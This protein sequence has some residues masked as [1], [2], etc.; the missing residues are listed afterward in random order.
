MAGRIDT[1]PGCR[2]R[3]VS[4]SEQ[5]LAY[6]LPYEAVHLWGKSDRCEQNVNK[7]LLTESRAYILVKKRLY[8]H[9]N[10]LRVYIH[11]IVKPRSTSGSVLG[12]QYGPNP[13]IQPSM[14]P[15]K[16]LFSGCNEGNWSYL[17]PLTAPSVLLRIKSHFIFYHKL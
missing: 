7:H 8:N 6:C 5:L 1:C 15:S 16:L 9:A 10:M 12:P 14:Q 3:R 17:G 13:S 2:G 4:L 11:Q